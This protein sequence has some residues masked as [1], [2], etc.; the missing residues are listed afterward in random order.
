MASKEPQ[1]PT[2]QVLERAFGLL[3]LL[4]SSQETLTLKQISE[5]PHASESAAT[6]FGSCPR[7]HVMRYAAP[8]GGA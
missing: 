4:A 3:D 7:P 6:C 2:I 1:T 8:H 5:T